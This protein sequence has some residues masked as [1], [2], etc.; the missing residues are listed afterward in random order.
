V[1]EKKFSGRNSAN[2]EF[3]NAVS[4][5]RLLKFSGII[6][7]RISLQQGMATSRSFHSVWESVLFR[8]FWG[9]ETVSLIVQTISQNTVEVLR[10]TLTKIH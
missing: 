8:A 4:I 5:S 7:G 9:T 2:I 10:I 3:G 1:H 6:T